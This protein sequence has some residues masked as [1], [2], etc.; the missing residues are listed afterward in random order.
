VARAFRSDAI[1]SLQFRPLLPT[2]TFTV[3]VQADS[4]KIGRFS[5]TTACCREAARIEDYFSGVAQPKLKSRDFC[6]FLRAA[7]N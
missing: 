6:Q 3:V 1:V 5:R 7:S 2:W 4:P